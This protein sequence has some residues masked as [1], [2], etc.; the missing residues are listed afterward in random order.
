MKA[1]GPEVSGTG[2]AWQQCCQVGARRLLALSERSLQGARRHTALLGLK[3]LPMTIACSVLTS[4]TACNVP[5]RARI[6]LTAIFSGGPGLPCRHTWPARCLP[7]LCF[8]VALLLPYSWPCLCLPYC[9]WDSI[10]KHVKIVYHA[11]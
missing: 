5:K 10:V 11:M 9:S 6:L 2:G 4:Q 8:L 1:F 3:V 7:T